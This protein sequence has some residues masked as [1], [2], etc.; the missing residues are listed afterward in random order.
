MLYYP[1]VG[2]YDQK[3]PE[4]IKYHMD[5]AEYM[6]IDAWLAWYWSPLDEPSKI[7]GENLKLYM[8]YIEQHNRSVKMCISFDT[9]FFPLMGDFTI[10]DVVWHIEYALDNYGNRSSYL[11]VDGH[12]VMFIYGTPSFT[13]DQWNYIIKKVRYDG[14]DPVFFIEVGPEL[15]P[16]VYP[17][18][19][20]FQSLGGFY[21]RLMEI[22]DG[23]FMV[24]Q[25][26]YGGLKDFNRSLVWRTGVEVAGKKIASSSPTSHRATEPTYGLRRCLQ[27]PF[28]RF[29]GETACITMKLGWMQSGAVHDG[30]SYTLGTN[31]LNMPK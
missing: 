15:S 4:T 14:Y 5:M 31:G 7:H 1:L 25:I 20:I 13:F 28:L 11:K 26:G 12:P 3:D 29:R 22:F 16:E 2:V 8:D 19:D 23:A 6:G 17:H 24:S 10:D 21:L 30:S 27:H 18:P 9:A